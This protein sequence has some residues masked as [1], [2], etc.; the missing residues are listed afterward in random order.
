MRPIKSTLVVV[1]LVA[2]AVAVEFTATEP[3][4]GSDPHRV[5]QAAVD[6]T[7]PVAASSVD[8]ETAKPERA[9]DARLAADPIARE[10]P[11]L[12]D[13]PPQ[14]QLQTLRWMRDTPGSKL[15]SAFPAVQA[16]DLPMAE[17]LE[18]ARRRADELIVTLE[19]RV[20]AG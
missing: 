2:A 11:R 20:R 17:R 13:R 16:L 15:V 18:R 3:G 6:P 9:V 5:V 10:V 19:R 1:A 7:V 12:L 8:R 14:L 4:D